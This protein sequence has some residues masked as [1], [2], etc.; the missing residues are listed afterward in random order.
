[1]KYS[2]RHISDEELD[3]LFRDAHASEGQ[4]SLF[5][6]EFWSEMEAML[7][8]EKKRKHGFY[9]IPLAATAI[10]FS[11]ILFYPSETQRVDILGKSEKQ[12]E[13]DS[14]PDSKLTLSQ[15]GKRHEEDLVLKTQAVTAAD[16]QSQGIVNKAAHAKTT[17]RRV[18]TYIH[19]ERSNHSNNAR[20]DFNKAIEPVKIHPLMEEPLIQEASSVQKSPIAD[21]DSIRLEPRNER[22]IH[23]EI[24]ALP[25]KRLNES[26][27]WY[28]ELGP[29]IGQSP[30]LSPG[31]KRNA[32]GGA[33]LG[34]GFTKK[35]D[36]AL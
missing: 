6:P 34:G 15:N 16:L 4:E 35:I 21:L 12:Y 3:Q 5:V 11:I 9:W 10:V 36:N 18:E 25:K 1:M 20:S 14:N 13:N 30:Y 17:Q 33:V 27:Q 2:D 19:V 28:L 24:A 8:A 29:T 26:N 31:Q 22:I 7:P 32:V 23:E